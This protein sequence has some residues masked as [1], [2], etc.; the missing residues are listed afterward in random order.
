MRKLTLL[1][2]LLAFATTLAFAGSPPGSP[3]QP[4]DGKYLEVQKVYMSQIG[5]SEIPEGS[6]WGPNVQKY[7]SSVH[8]YSPAAWCAAFVHWSNSTAGIKDN[9]TAWSPTAQNNANLVYY[10]G[11]YLQPPRPADVFTIYFPSL[12]RIAHT[13]FI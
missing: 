4:T 3:P 1:S 12:K 8:V 5:L 13:G 9:I 7:L 6:N 11:H 10:N 2:F